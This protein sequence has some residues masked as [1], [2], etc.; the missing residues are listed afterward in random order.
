MMATTKTL[1]LLLMVLVPGGLLVLG[2]IVLARLVAQ[3]ARAGQGPHGRRLARA[4]ATVRWRDV[5]RETRSLV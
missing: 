2:A 5:V 1:G 4:L 3:Q